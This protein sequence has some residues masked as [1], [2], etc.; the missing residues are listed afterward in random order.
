MSIILLPP[1][2]GKTSAE[3]KSKLQLSKLSF[4]ELSP[5]RE[6]TIGGLI[7]LSNGSPA[8][9]RTTLGVSAKQDWEIERNQILLTAPVAPA[10][11]I[12]TGVLYDAIGFSSL[13]AAQMKKLTTMTFVQSA[14]FG[15]ISLADNIP[16]Y[17]LSGD[18]TLPKV[19][20]MSSVWAKSTTE[21]LSDREELIIDLRS[22]MYVKL[23]PIPSGANAV[24]PKILQRMPSGPPKVVSHHN[25]ATK[26]RI[27]RAMVES[28]GA[29][30]SVDQLGSVISALGADV[31]VKKASKS[32][33]PVTM[34]VV[35]DVL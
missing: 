22:G 7:A 12:Y 26:G 30:K 28:K 23:G 13:T 34:E 33:G 3:G 16:A 18:T 19:G 35:V 24:F 1:S 25:K 17:R 4:S 9:A 20:T 2:E 15:L 8:K 6:K 32:G 27:V 11:Q 10:W 29:I 14:L 5:L 31:V 21:I